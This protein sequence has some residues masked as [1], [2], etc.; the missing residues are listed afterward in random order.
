MAVAL[1][2]APSPLRLV[3]A[4]EI[5]SGAPLVSPGSWTRRA[6]PPSSTVCPVSRTRT[7]K[8]VGSAAPAHGFAHCQSIINAPSDSAIAI[9]E[10][11]VGSPIVLSIQQRLCTVNE[12]TP[13]YALK[14]H[15]VPHETTPTS[16]PLAPLPLTSGPPLSPAQASLPG[17][18]AQ[19]MSSVSKASVP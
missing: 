4:T 8:P 3:A 5:V 17:R 15:P 12:Y 10:G 14:P 16:R 19:I 18:A 11:G 2:G 6:D 13:G 7:R 9:A 1:I